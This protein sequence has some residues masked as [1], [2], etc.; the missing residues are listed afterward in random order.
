MFETRVDTSKFNA[1]IRAFAKESRKGMEEVV[2][3]RAGIIVGN[4][5]AVTPPADAKGRSTGKK[6]QITSEAKKRGEDAVKADIFKLFPTSA[7]KEEKILAMIERG[8]KFKTFSIPRK[9]PNY[10][11]N[12]GDLKRFHAQARSK[13]TGRVRTEYGKKMA[14][15]RKSLRTAYAKEMAKRVGILNAGWLNAAQK[16][17]T[18]KSKTPSWITR[19]GSKPGRVD[20]RYTK[21][22]LT[23][24]LRNEMPYYPKDKNRRINKALERETYALEKATEAMIERK[25]KRATQR[26]R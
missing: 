25:A 16:L 18:A 7:A 20:F 15:T 2:K 26:M 9:V 23:I 22:G 19:H 21:S 14:V 5:I 24:I 17:K 12:I 6:G 8:D 10:A 1:A 11:A 13:S 3:Q 4:L